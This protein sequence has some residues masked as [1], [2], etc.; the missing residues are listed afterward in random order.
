MEEELDYTYDARDE[1]CKFNKSE[2]VVTLKGGKALPKNETLLQHWLVKNGPISVGLNA[3]A[4]M[5]YR[6]GVSHPWS[7]LCSPT[8]IDHG[9]L[10]VGYGK[11]QETVVLMNL[12]FVFVPTGTVKLPQLQDQPFW[13][14][15]NSWGP[16]WGEFGY[17]RL[18]R[19][20]GCCGIN[21]MA[22]TSIV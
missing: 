10:I 19:G 13:K 16:D 22:T 1:K 8:R 17:Y 2:V 7:Y 6:G 20:S 3:N 4:M 5:F 14:I 12:L 11:G 21:D 9:V 15:K 18:W